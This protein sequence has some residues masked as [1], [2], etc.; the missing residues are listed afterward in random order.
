M[1]R[2]EEKAKDKGE[3]HTELMRGEVPTAG[4]I[5]VLLQNT[6][7]REQKADPTLDQGYCIRNLA[8]VS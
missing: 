5:P 6:V 2:E 3:I 1:Q 7:K 8:K 4:L